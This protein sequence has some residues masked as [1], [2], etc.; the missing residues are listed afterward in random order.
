MRVPTFVQPDS[1]QECL[2]SMINIPQLGL[3]LLSPDGRP[4]YPLHEELTSNA[5]HRL[6]LHL[7]ALLKFRLF[8]GDEEDC[9]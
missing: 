7:L 4:L 2:F 5:L 9:D 8:L 1:E 6:E 3:K